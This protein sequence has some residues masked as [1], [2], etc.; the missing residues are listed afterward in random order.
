MSSFETRKTAK[1]LVGIFFAMLGLSFASVPLYRMF[2]QETGFG[3]TPSIFKAPSLKQHERQIRVHFSATIARGFPWD[4]KAAQ[5][6]IDVTLGENALAFYK[7][8]NKSDH[9][10]T[11]MAVYNV[12]PERAAPYFNKVACFCFESQELKSGQSMD[13]PVLFYLDPQMN[14][15][16]LLNDVKEVILSYTFFEYKP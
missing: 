6:H 14:E 2:C 11:G 3:G 4:F 12:S 5:P 10:I 7:A 15:D 13:M 9:T 1:I 8:H 16:P